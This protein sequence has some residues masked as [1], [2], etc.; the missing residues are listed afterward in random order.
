MAY[1]AWGWPKALL[2]GA[3]PLDSEAIYVAQASSEYVV[4][5]FN[6]TIQVWSGGQHRVKLGEL[7]RTPE[8]VAEEG[9]NLRAHWCPQKRVLAV[10]VS[11]AVRTRSVHRAAGF[12]ASST[13]AV[14]VFAPPSSPPLL[15]VPRK[16]CA[17]CPPQ[18]RPPCAPCR[19]R[20]TTTCTSTPS[21]CPAR[22]CGACR[23]G[24]RCGGS[25]CTSPTGGL[26]WR[27]LAA[28]GGRGVLCSAPCK[29]TPLAVGKAGPVQHTWRAALH[30]SRCL[31]LALQPCTP[32]PCLQHTPGLWPRAHC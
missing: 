30:S 20:H 25:I 32:A 5:V 6:A 21:T 19:R 23:T 3:T 22:H 1:F 13:A 2:T 24:R 11:A 9:A 15:C 12:G 31:V 17:A 14:G 18:T 7:H 26:P 29:V 4:A 27:R 10:A 8:A 28:V 16:R